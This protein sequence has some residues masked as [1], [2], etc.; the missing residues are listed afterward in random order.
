MRRLSILA[1]TI[2]FVLW[3][4]LLTQPGSH[5]IARAQPEPGVP[6][7]DS[8]WNCRVLYTLYSGDYDRIDVPVEMTINFTKLLMQ[9]NASGT[10]DENSLRVIEYESIEELLLEIPSQFDRASSFNA[11]SDAVGT[12]AWIVNGTTL[13]GT[14]RI[15]GLYFDTLEQGPKNPPHYFGVSSRIIG[16]HI[17]I[18]NERL[19]VTVRYQNGIYL[20][21]L[22]FDRNG[23]SVF[24]VDEEMIDSGNPY[25]LLVR[26][27]DTEVNQ[28]GWTDPFF[29]YKAD[30]NAS[31]TTVRNGSVVQEISLSNIS[32]NNWK[33]FNETLNIDAEL[34]FKIYKLNTRI[35]IGT[36][37]TVNEDLEV[38][39]T[40]E[41]IFLD[42]SDLY[43]E[44]YVDE[45]HNGIFSY[46]EGFR[47]FFRDMPAYGIV[48]SYSSADNAGLASIPNLDYYTEVWL[49]EYNAPQEVPPIL[50]PA[51]RLWID[52]GNW[53]TGQTIELENILF[54]HFGDWSR[55]IGEVQSIRYPP[56]FVTSLSIH[57]IDGNDLDLDNAELKVYNS[58]GKVVRTGY[59]NSKGWVIFPI[60]VGDYTVSA[61]WKGIEVTRQSVSVTQ[62]TVIDPLRCDV[63]SL[64]IYASETEG[65]AVEEVTVSIYLYN[66]TRVSSSE[67]DFSGYA[68]FQQLPKGDFVVKTYYLRQQFGIAKSIQ[69]DA[70]DQLNITGR[71]QTGLSGQIRYDIV[72]AIMIGGF[73]VATFVVMVKVKDEK[74]IL[75]LLFCVLIS[76]TFLAITYA[77]SLPLFSG[78]SSTGISASYDNNSGFATLGDVVKIKWRDTDRDG[79]LD[80]SKLFVTA[81]NGSAVLAI[82][83]ESLLVTPN[84]SYSLFDAEIKEIA[85]LDKATSN[86]V[87]YQPLLQEPDFSDTT[88]QRRLDLRFLFFMPDR[89][90]VALISTFEMGKPYVQIEWEIFD[91]GEGEGDYKIYPEIIPLQSMNRLILPANYTNNELRYW[92]Q[93]DGPKHANPWSFET[94]WPMFGAH[95]ANMHVNNSNVFLHSGENYDIQTSVH[96]SSVFARYSGWVHNK[97]DS[98][99]QYDFWVDWD[100]EEAPSSD[101]EV[102]VWVPDFIDLNA[103]QVFLTP[104]G[105]RWSEY[106]GITLTEGNRGENGFSSYG[107]CKRRLKISIPAVRFTAD[108]GDDT[109]NDYGVILNDEFLMRLKVDYLIEGLTTYEFEDSQNQWYGTRNVNDPWMWLMGTE[110]DLSVGLIFTKRLDYLVVQADH[111]EMYN[112]ATMGFDLSLTEGNQ[113]AFYTNLVLLHSSEAARQDDNSDGVWNMFDEDL[114]DHLPFSTHFTTRETF[115]QFTYDS[116][117]NENAGH[118]YLLMDRKP[119]ENY[120]DV[121]PRYTVCLPRSI[122]QHLESDDALYRFERNGYYVY[123]VWQANEVRWRERAFDPL[124]TYQLY[125]LFAFLGISALLCVK[126]R[127]IVKKYRI[128]LLLFIVGLAARLAFQSLAPH[129]SG[130]DAAIYG[131]VA[132]NFLNHGKFELSVISLEPH[133]IQVGAFPPQITNPFN[134]PSRLLFPSLIMSSFAIL[135][136][137]FF[138]LK[139]V[140]VILGALVIIPTFY[141]AKKL[142]NENVAIAAATLVAFHPSLVYYSG[143]HPSTGI[144]TTLLAMASLSAMAYES[145]KAAVIAGLFAGITLFLR[146]EFGFL[147]LVAIATYYILRLRKKKDILIITSMFLMM[148]TVLFIV[149]YVVVGRSPFPS[150]KMLGGTIGET[151]A[152]SLW[153][154]LSDPNFIQI[155]LYNALYGW[156]YVLFIDSPFIF[157]LAVAGLLLY[158]KRWKAVSIL[159]LFP[160]FGILAYS[161]VV[162]EQPHIRFLVEYIPVIS[163]LAASFIVSLAEFLLPRLTGRSKLKINIKL[164][165]ILTIFVFVE[166]AFMT[167]FPHYLAINTAMENLAWKFDD[168]KVYDWIE[169][170]TSPNSVIMA[171]SAVYVYYIGREVVVTPRP[172]GTIDVDLSMIRS[173]IRRY[174]VDYVVLDRTTISTSDLRII[175]EDPVFKAPNGFNLVYWSED[176]ANYDPRVLIYDVRALHD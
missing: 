14:A 48:D 54:A 115:A 28:H 117:F 57:L 15:Y 13:A 47:W 88:Y 49:G 104:D 58:E 168:G 134:Y 25:T 166:I 84:S 153:E 123:D 85:Y 164:K 130:T 129:F 26:V 77:Q 139:A 101:V 113:A 63:Y 17:I 11:S 171:P 86:Y 163:I 45:N 145:R 170:N 38:D 61:F 161:L 150:T 128:I 82:D 73:A 56:T 30:V 99:F 103:S 40:Y 107:G 106:E 87:L 118:Q 16:N 60:E 2:A 108:D 76:T 20:E 111:T 175:R 146:I 149:A 90:Q 174:N 172:I 70:N 27:S 157:I 12:V 152:P 65:G 137:S 148:L 89:W 102:E 80:D 55:A 52:A 67:T 94:D 32:L 151:R 124:P 62:D 8:S 3:S 37:L 127:N 42:N 24:D 143:V 79:E 75:G 41:R 95:I 120:W 121:P 64:S 147:L 69:F 138:A 10:F 122:F 112:K 23:D 154:T 158:I 98:Y 83:S 142:F 91:K 162:R 109:G 135:G 119:I 72:Y 96:A 144:A 36:M 1:L 81:S 66:G 7:W 176:P 34:T 159:Y 156:W 92:N 167:F 18:Q 31:I 133:Y 50:G 105:S 165:R 97:E 21:K 140:D 33:S 6:W 35:Y 114:S 29:V 100:G 169:A 131:S 5:I 53:S 116:G 4:L 78:S 51:L 126:H 132:R 136:Q 19:N 160:I 110:Q 22:S 68:L 173:V 93:K 141:L 59:S 43:K 74:F 39:Y 125:A 9:S 155:R 46:P 44:W 71:V